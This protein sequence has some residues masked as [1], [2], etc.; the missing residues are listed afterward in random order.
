[1]MMLPYN[2]LQLKP[3]LL[4]SSTIKWRKNLVVARVVAHPAKELQAQNNSCAICL[5]Q[6]GMVH[7]II[8]FYI[9]PLFDF[10]LLYY[11]LYIT[12]VSK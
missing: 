4:L 3:Y 11:S 8:P 1:M 6:K 12:S 7:R 10:I 2:L 9:F 5:S